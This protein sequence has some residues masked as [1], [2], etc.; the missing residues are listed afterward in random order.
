MQAACLHVAA[1]PLRGSE[2]G[3]TR[4]DAND[5]CTLRHGAVEITPGHGVSKPPA[6]KACLTVGEVRNAISA[7]A[8]SDCLLPELI[9]ATYI[10]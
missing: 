6:V 9:P 5:R 3:C 8:A 7:F 2:D 10:E 4:H 1:L